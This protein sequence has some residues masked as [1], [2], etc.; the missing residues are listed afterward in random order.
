MPNLKM[1]EKQMT[2]EN[3]LML[4]NDF[5]VPSATNTVVEEPIDDLNDFEGIMMSFP[6]IKIPGGGSTQFE[7][8][9]DNPQKPD[10]LPAIEGIILFNHNTNAYWEEGAEFDMNAS[11][12]CS[13]TDGKTGYGTPGGAC[14]DCPYNQYET[15]PNGGKGKA[16]KNMR[17]LYILQNDKLMPINLLLPPTSLKAY[18]TFV[19]NAFIMR[20]RPLWG[21]LV[22]IELR[23]ETNG[24]NNYA[25]AV[26][27][28]LGD[29]TGEKLAEIKNYA[30]S[31][32]A[33]INEMLQQRAINTEN[34]NESLESITEVIEVEGTEG[35]PFS[36]VEG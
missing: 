10:Y 22:R 6:R 36:A 19:Q 17:S 4:L 15:D 14:V 8:P 35:E 29:F 3:S 20:N 32:R 11:P 12:K 23:K 18:S 21:S 2:N 25:V 5:K 30:I 9:S 7:I 24:A 26:F 31:A 27:T 33:S 28:R 34:R 1:E 13:S 16:C